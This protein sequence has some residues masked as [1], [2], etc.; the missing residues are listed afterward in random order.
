ME[1]I[2]FKSSKFKVTIEVFESVPGVEAFLGRGG[3]YCVRKTAR[4]TTQN[5]HLDNISFIIINK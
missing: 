2:K 5:R 1:A 3:C 4:I